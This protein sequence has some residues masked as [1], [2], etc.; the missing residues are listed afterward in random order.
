MWLRTGNAEGIRLGKDNISCDMYL[1]KAQKCQQVSKIS[2]TLG[3]LA[4]LLVG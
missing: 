4:V 1:Y 2:S 3:S